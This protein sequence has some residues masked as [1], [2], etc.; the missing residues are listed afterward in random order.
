MINMA[1]NKAPDS[2]PL[3][4]IKITDDFWGRY[5]KLVR[6]VI[7]PYQWD[8]LNDNIPGAEKSHAI[9]N[10]RIAA[11]LEEGEF[12]GAVFQDSDVAKWLEAVAYSLENNPDTELEQKADWV[13]DI[14]E[15]AQQPDGYLNTYYTIKEP[16][17]RWTNL[18]EGHE[19][20]CAGHM[21]EAA[22]A[23]YNA[24]G[25]RK[26]LDVVCRFADYICDVFGSEP[27]K[28]RG[29]PG[30][31]E[32]ELALVKLY[33]VTGN[34]KFLDLARYFIEERGKEPYYFDI[35]YEKR[36][37]TEIFPELRGYG[38]KY[39]QT[40]LPIYKQYTIEGHAVRALYMLSGIAD[41]AIE[42]QDQVMHDVCKRLWDNVVNRRMYV[43][44][45]VGS[46]PHGEAFTFDYDLPNDT[47]YGETCASIALIFFAHRML[48]LE[49]DSQ[50]ADV[51]ERALYNTVLAAM[52]LD[53][54]SFFYV[55]P[56]EVYPEAC[57]KDFGKQHIKPVRQKWFSVACC[58]PN[59]ARLLASLGQY[60]YSVKDNILYTHLYI[61][62]NAN[63]EIDG[64]KIEVV[65]E[66]QYPWNGNIEFRINSQVTKEF[67]VA[68]RIPGW[69]KNMVIKV[70][71]ETIEVEQRAGY[72]YITREWTQDDSVVISIEM[73]VMKVKSNPLVRENI[74][75][76]ALQ[77]GPLVYCL[78][79]ADNG[80][81]LHQLFL[82]SNT[83]FEVVHDEDFLSGLTVITAKGYKIDNTDWNNN[84][85]KTD[86]EIKSTPATL[87]FIPYFAWANRGV[88]EMTVWVNE[89][90]P[91]SC[92]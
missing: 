55:N 61:G 36:G 31:Q 29:Y 87:K 53:G 39:W 41:I 42:S 64:C 49:I 69:S 72:A 57:E 32:I 62:S 43:T 91:F 92:K 75:K 70:N 74:G 46:T 50:Y 90:K 27:G 9:K 88:G 67:T 38:R 60:I 52:A 7:I 35:E 34:K 18:A 10:F 30:H 56:L 85:Y 21:I 2:I 65:Q 73:P 78:E 63:I 23:Y 79:E 51:M 71:N 76:V 13:I 83:E 12:Y 19:L 26:L 44:G 59:I 22:I 16:E 24:T 54:R 25:K 3:K 17:N 66:T 33:R 68:F 6:D 84:L 37:R 14:I 80:K 28:I 8:A 81:N 11:G 77:R 48:K 45:A 4:N 40:H 82:A 47:V 15:K 86:V 89:D 5:V 58:P 20:Y 1:K